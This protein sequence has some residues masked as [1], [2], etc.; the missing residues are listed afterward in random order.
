MGQLKKGVTEK[1]RQYPLNTGCSQ[2]LMPKPHH[3]LGYRTEN[4]V[5]SRLHE[6][7][8]HRGSSASNDHDKLEAKETKKHLQDQ[9]GL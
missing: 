2:D 3:K 6:K 8:L 5:N 9:C 4:K 1:C 7:R